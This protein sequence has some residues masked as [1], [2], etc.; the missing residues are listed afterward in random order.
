MR[1][2]RRLSERRHCHAMG[3][4]AGHANADDLLEAGTRTGQQPKHAGQQWSVVGVHNGA[5]Y[6]TWAWGI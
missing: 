5:Q 2:H 4:N 6:A 3:D 1:C